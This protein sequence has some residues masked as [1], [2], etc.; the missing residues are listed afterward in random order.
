MKSSTT[1]IA[2]T[3]QKHFDN[4]S[5]HLPKPFVNKNKE[6]FVDE[7]IFFNFEKIFKTYKK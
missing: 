1:K 3:G 2:K 4:H 7:I 5:N 6:S